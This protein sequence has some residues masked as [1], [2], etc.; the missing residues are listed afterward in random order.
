MRKIAL[1]SVLILCVLYV[2]AAEAQV[3]TEENLSFENKVNNWLTENNVPAVGIGIIENGK[4]KYVKVFGE[5]KK[6]TPAPDNAVF[7]I[8]SMTKPVVTMLTLKLVEA[9]Q[10]DLNEPLCHYWVDPDIANN[11]WHK[12]LT[13]RRVLT[14]QTGFPNWRYMLPDKKLAFDF[15]PGT[16]YQYSGEG[17]EYLRNALEHKFNKPIEKLLDSI[18]FKPL[19]M[20]NTGYWGKNV[21]KL[22]YAHFHD[23]QGNEFDLPYP[24][25]V[26]AADLLFTSI[27]DY[28]KFE[29][30][31]I[32]GAGLSATLFDDMIEPHVKMKE[33]YAKGLGWEVITDLPDG[34][35]SLEHGGSDPGVKT[36]AI[37]LPKSKRG[38]VVLTNGD[39][40]MFVYNNIIKESIDIGEKILEYM[41]GSVARKAIALPDEI[42]NRYVGTYL[43]SYGRNLTIIK[44]GSTLI[45]SGK[46]V[47]TV[48][49]YPESEN[50]F[51]VK[52]FDIQFE[53]VKDNSLIITSDGK[54]ACTAKK[55][56]EKN[57]K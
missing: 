55:I 25:G 5:L 50:K 46:G 48:K 12:K 3:K 6:G 19:G 8:A 24:M 39:N 36:I 35:Y 41:V 43:D 2:N 4:I 29:I 44:E 52:D 15:E 21:N 31:V 32:N 45:A 33:H 14:H 40:G 23:A 7:N 30:D 27:E 1:L 57:E 11:P 47:P 13:T 54:I 37:I 26:S 51:F 42:L 49:L 56:K 28:C 18:I 34:E 20:K 53:F 22:N 10:W 9:G 38:I 17:F 16:Q